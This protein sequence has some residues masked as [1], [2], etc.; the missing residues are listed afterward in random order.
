MG[1]RS[2]TIPKGGHMKALGIFGVILIFLG[3]FGFVFPR[4]AFSE[5]MP[6]IPAFGLGPLQI[7]SERGALSIS[8]VA[9]GA[10]VI[11]GV[12]LIVVRARNQ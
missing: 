1:K 8:D 7:Q 3:I 4:I 5:E 2:K 6:A 12:A 9:A 11:S 10:A